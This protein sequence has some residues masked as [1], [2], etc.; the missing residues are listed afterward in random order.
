MPN[1]CSNVATLTHKDPT[2]VARLVKAADENTGVL[3]EFI[4]IPE[5][6]R[7]EKGYFADQD[8]QAAM[9]AQGKANLKKYGYKDWYDFSVNEWGTKWD[10]CDVTATQPFEDT[11][12][13]H[14]DTAWS[15]PIEAYQ[16]LEALG[17]EILAYYYESGMQFAGIYQDGEDDSYQDWG[18]SKGAEETLPSELDETFEISVNQ[19][20]WEDE[21]KEEVQ[22][23]YEDGVKKL[24]EKAE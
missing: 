20:M 1:W 7:I 17:F 3:N 6:L 10:L 18:D 21:D 12:L 15:P 23:W 2:M 8:K 4:P 16:K 14:F 9:E 13:L 19:A 5:D 22:V 24:E 11:V